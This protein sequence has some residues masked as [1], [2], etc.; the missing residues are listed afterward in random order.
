MSTD[1]QTP[2]P[3]GRGLEPAPYS[4][5]GVRA[6]H[7]PSQPIEG[8]GIFAFSFRRSWFRTTRAPNE[9]WP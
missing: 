7:T 8:E 5:T 6:I 2:S 4:D 9:V 3:S 1:Q